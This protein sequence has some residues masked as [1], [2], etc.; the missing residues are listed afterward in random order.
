VGEFCA[1]CGAALQVYEPLPRIKKR[2]FDA[3]RKNPGISAERLRLL[4]W[5]DDPNGGPESRQNVHVQINQLNRLLVREG[6]RIQGHV[7]NGYKLIHH[8]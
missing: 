3:V 2:I 4:V 7:T 6:L 8:A 1:A 5:H